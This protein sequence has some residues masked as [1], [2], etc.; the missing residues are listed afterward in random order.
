M[1]ETIYQR[2]WV[3][4][5]EAELKLTSLVKTEDDT[6]TLSIMSA[7][8]VEFVFIHKEKVVDDND[9]AER[10]DTSGRPDRSKTSDTEDE[11]GDDDEQSNPGT[12]T[13]I[14]THFKNQF[15]YGFMAIGAS[16][17]GFNSVI[18]PVICIDATHLKARTKGILLVVVCKEGNEMIYPLAFGF[19]NSECT[20]LWTWFLKK[21][22]KVIQYPD[23]VMLGSDRHNGIFN[24]MEAIFPDAAHGICAYHLAQNLKRFCKQRDDVIWL[25]YRVTYAYRI[26]DFDHAMA[27]LKETYCKVYDELLGT[28]VEKFSRV[29]IPRKKYFLMTNNIDESI[30]SCLLAVQKLPTIAVDSDFWIM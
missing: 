24:A 27:E 23:R 11:I 10:I 4:R 18:R 22:R 30:N 25:Y 14:K 28:R 8:E 2:T 7:D 26:E 6:V 17:E 21:L 12:V 15:K 5:D 19:A 16:I 9:S 3:S 13:K 1:V 29:H 20:Q